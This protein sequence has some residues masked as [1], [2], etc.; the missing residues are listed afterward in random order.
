MA[1]MLVFSP[2]LP[3]MVS[4]WSDMLPWHACRLPYRC[5]CRLT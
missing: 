3:S 4:S 5:H 1:V 2:H